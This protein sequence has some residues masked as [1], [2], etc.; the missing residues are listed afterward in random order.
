MLVQSTKE[1]NKQIQISMLAKAWSDPRFKAELE[2]DP[3]AVSK[4]EG[5]VFDGEMKISDKE[6]SPNTFYLPPPPSGS[7]GLT[8]TDL[9]QKASDLISADKEMF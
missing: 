1:K 5:L 8:S 3:T 9:E 4:K 2:A 7:G 6:A